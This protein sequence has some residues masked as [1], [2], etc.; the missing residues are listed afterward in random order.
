MFDNDRYC[1]VVIYRDKNFV[2]GQYTALLKHHGVYQQI[3]PNY[4]YYKCLVNWCKKNHY[5]IVKEVL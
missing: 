5:K 3:S 4:T 2:S 1:E